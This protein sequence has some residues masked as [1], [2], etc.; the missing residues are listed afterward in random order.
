MRK[1][2]NQLLMAAARDGRRGRSRPI[3]SF[4]PTM[5]KEKEVKGGRGPSQNYAAGRSHSLV[6]GRSN[7]HPRRKIPP[8]K[9]RRGQGSRGVK[10][11]RADYETH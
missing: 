1:A 6:G 8:E 7:L 4:G 11:G 3:G 9:T 2:Q 10:G 5:G